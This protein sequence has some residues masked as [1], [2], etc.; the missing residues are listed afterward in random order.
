M[1]DRFRTGDK[2][3]GKLQKYSPI[4]I[5]IVIKV[6]KWHSPKGNLTRTLYFV[7]DEDDVEHRFIGASRLKK[8][9][10]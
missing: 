7:Q 6:T 3:T 2:V 8:V 9:E 5:G 10:D 1:A 4:I